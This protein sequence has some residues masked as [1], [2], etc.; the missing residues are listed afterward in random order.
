MKIK[1]HGELHVHQL[2]QALFEELHQLEEEF[3][4]RHS[5]DITLYLTPT[6]GLGTPV[7]CKDQHGKKVEVIFNTGPYKSA[8][9]DYEI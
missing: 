9:D 6:N 2:R 7:L 8:A 4:V 5:K 3:L 1:F